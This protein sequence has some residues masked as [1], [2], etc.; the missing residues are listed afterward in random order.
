MGP[1]LTNSLALGQG[2]QLLVRGMALFA[3]RQYSDLGFGLG[4]RLDFLR[5]DRDRHALGVGLGGDFLRESVV[6]GESDSGPTSNWNGALVASLTGRVTVW[7]WL[8]LVGEVDLRAV[9]G[10]LTFTTGDDSNRHTYSFSH[11]R[12]GIIAGIEFA[13]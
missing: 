9:F 13:M 8:R 6:A 11:W 7:R 12:P 4:L 10:S 1:E 5:G 3:D 2:L